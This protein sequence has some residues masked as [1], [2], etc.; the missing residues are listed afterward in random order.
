MARRWLT[1]TEL[2]NCMSHDMPEPDEQRVQELAKDKKRI[3]KRRRR[4]CGISWFMGIRLIG[5]RQ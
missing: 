4:L 3:Q 5:A 2:A 1:I